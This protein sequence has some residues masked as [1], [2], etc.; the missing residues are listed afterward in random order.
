[1]SYAIYGHET[2][3]I[4]NTSIETKHEVSKLIEYIQ[5]FNHMNDLSSMYL[6]MLRLTV[7]DREAQINHLVVDLPGKD[8]YMLE[9]GDPHAPDEQWDASVEL[10]QLL[11]KTE[12]AV[13]VEL[14]IEYDI[15]T[16][17]FEDGKQ[18]GVHYWDAG[19]DVPDSLLAAT[20]HKIV[21]YYD[22]YEYVNMFVQ[23]NAG[24]RQMIVPYDS[25]PRLVLEESRS[26][27]SNEEN[28]KDIEK[29]HC[30][31]FVLDMQAEN[32][33]DDIPEQRDAVMSKARKYAEKYEILNEIDDPFEDQ[34]IMYDSPTVPNNMVEEYINDVQKIIDP[35]WNCNAWIHMQATF[36][37]AGSCPF[38][39]MQLVINDDG[40]I[41]KKYY[42]I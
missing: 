13:D 30:N 32:N 38:A 6:G 26:I 28:C 5:Q 24:R 4:H 2:H 3:H 8:Y 10:M 33:W 41:E 11:A 35:A 20:E 12:D 23:D 36:V 16:A 19:L 21:E 1:M 39:V 29:W 17:G 14:E 37:S 40:K 9:D 34:I 31:E 27:L 7:D 18:Y 15:M 42:R 22:S 25:E